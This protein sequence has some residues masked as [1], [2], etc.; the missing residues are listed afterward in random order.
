MVDSQ[1]YSEEKILKKDLNLVQRIC[2]KMGFAVFRHRRGHIYCPKRYVVKALKL[3]DIHEVEGFGQLAEN[4]IAQK[5][6]RL[7]FEKLYMLRQAVLNVARLSGSGTSMAEVGVYKGGGTYFI[8]S[9]VD[10]VFEEK[11]R[12]HAFDTFEGHAPEDISPDLDGPHGP[13]KFADTSYEDVK[14]YLSAFPNVLVHKGR[15]ED[16]MDEV[17]GESF[18]FV[19]LDVDLYAPTRSCLDYF[20]DSLLPGG[21]I[22]VDD[23][24]YKT[25][26]GAKKAVDSFVSERDNF[27]KFH[28]ETG[29]C[30]LIRAS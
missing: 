21:I 16:R 26:L 6:T 8:A 7:D 5:R 17:S 27:I 3:I 24:G 29:Q 25:C 2:R 12:I 9:V 22:M 19:H 28:L 13:T 10:Q 15:F 18:S 1:V 4:V 11:P 30:L 20:S 14:A 23:Y